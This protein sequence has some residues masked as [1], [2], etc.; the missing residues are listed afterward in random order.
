MGKANKKEVKRFSK[1]KP[2]YPTT[3]GSNLHDVTFH[4]LPSYS[5]RPK[6]DPVNKRC[7]TKRKLNFIFTYSA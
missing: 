7:K 3:L 6:P 2:F 1:Y 5:I 4:K